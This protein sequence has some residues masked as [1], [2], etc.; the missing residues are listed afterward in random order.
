MQRYEIEFIWLVQAKIYRKPQTS[1][2]DFDIYIYIIYIYICDGKNCNKSW[3][4]GDFP[5]K[6][7]NQS[8]D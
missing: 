5:L 2:F 7:L 4:P 8:N 1:T 6:A 3:F